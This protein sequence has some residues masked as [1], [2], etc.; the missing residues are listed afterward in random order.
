M[1]AAFVRSGLQSVY[2]SKTGS[3]RAASKRGDEQHCQ[4]AQQES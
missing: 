2:F 1:F 3:L 4:Q